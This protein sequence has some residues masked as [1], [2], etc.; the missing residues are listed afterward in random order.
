MRPNLGTRRAMMRTPWCSTTSQPK[1]RAKM[2]TKRGSW[3][4]SQAPW[5]SPMS[6][7]PTTRSPAADTT[8]VSA[9]GASLTRSSGHDGFIGGDREVGVALPARGVLHMRTPRAAQPAAQVGVV[10]QLAHPGRQLVRVARFEQQARDAVHG[11]LGERPDARG[12][13]RDA[14]A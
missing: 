5:S 2:S 7:A 10:P 6:L 4:I 11:R 1:C 3:K 13:H 12:K 14:M 9:E 8:E